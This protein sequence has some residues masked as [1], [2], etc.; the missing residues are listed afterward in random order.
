[1]NDASDTSFGDIKEAQGTHHPLFVY[2]VCDRTQQGFVVAG[3][4]GEC[5][6]AFCHDCKTRNLSAFE[7]YRSNDGIHLVPGNLN[8]ILNIAIII[9]LEGPIPYHDLS[10][11]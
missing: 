3:G 11:G 7:Q 4:E 8:L 9:K 2:I 1:M 6:A 10:I 5:T